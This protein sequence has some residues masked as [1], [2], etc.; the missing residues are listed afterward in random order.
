MC[1]VWGWGGVAPQYWCHRPTV[2]GA[3]DNKNLRGTVII[4]LFWEIFVSDKVV[5]LSVMIFFVYL[6]LLLAWFTFCIVL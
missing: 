5:L 6:P 4:A 1:M 3:I 2:W